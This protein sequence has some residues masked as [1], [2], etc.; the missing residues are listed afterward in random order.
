MTAMSQ[1]AS[2]ADRQE[3]ARQWDDAKLVERFELR[4]RLR[5]APKKKT[6][7]VTEETNGGSGI[8]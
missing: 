6:D 1:I 3:Y 5:E 8:A 2:E 4:P 7:F